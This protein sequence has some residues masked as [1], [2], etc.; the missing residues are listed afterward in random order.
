MNKVFNK[1]LQE[2]YYFT[3]LENGLPVFVIPK[4]GI[5]EKVAL[6][7]V[8]YGSTDNRW[9]DTTVP[10]GIAHFL[11]HQQFKK[12]QGDILTLFARYGASCNASTSYQT[13]T[14]HFSCTDHFDDNL[15]IL[16]KTVFSTYFNAEGI[17]KEKAIIEQELRMYQDMPHFRVY[18]NLMKN[19]YHKHPARIPIGGTV[20]TVR[21]ITENL[22]RRCYQTFYHPS[23]MVAV[24]CADMEPN[25]AIETLK[26]RITKIL[27][28]D[29]DKTF[30]ASKDITR[31]LPEEPADVKNHSS[32]EKMPVSTP[33]LLIGY[34]DTHSGMNGI[35]FLKQNIITDILLELIFGKSSRLYSKLYEE[36]LIDDRFGCGYIAYQTFGFVLISAET[37]KPD[38]LHSIILNELKK[39]SQQ[40]LCKK[41]QMEFLKRKMLGKFIWTF[42]SP[43]AIAALFAGY[44][45][46]NIISFLDGSQV[47]DTPN[48]I[49]KISADDIQERFSKILD[50]RY[51]SISLINP[52]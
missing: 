51:Q 26:N 3:H 10:N 35:P 28:V 39:L 29:M 23:N 25:R 44:Y 24:I 22:L 5:N 50:E 48:L 52:L 17:A 18:D 49:R 14:Y 47:Y 15:D 2:K 21:T 16:L 32:T 36:K 37:E 45:F 13:T 8:K 11:E 34:K 1:S 12:E 41:Q 30:D 38:V 20:E 33:Y 42:N 27:P 7:S 4:K 40:K 31:L 6:I 46:N 43:M 9:G 19:I